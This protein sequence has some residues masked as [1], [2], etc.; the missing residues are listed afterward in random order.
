MTVVIMD[1]MVIMACDEI[2]LG[3]FLHV[4]THMSSQ[5]DEKRCRWCYVVT[6]IEEAHTIE[7]SGMQGTN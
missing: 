2:H 5:V 3:P 7:I 6:T 4:T 1:T